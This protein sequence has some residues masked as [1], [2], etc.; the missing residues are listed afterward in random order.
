MKKNNLRKKKS[1]QEIQDEIFR[2]MSA[3]KRIETGSQ[4]WK[5]ARTIIGNEKLWRKKIQGTF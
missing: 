2:K 1:P 5:L 3:D 4:L